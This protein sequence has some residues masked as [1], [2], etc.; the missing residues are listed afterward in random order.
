MRDA[1]MRVAW[2]PDRG[3]KSSFYVAKTEIFVRMNDQSRAKAYAD[4]AVAVVTQKIRELPNEAQFSMEL[5]SAQAVLG[6][7]Q[8]ALAAM[9]KAVTLQPF[10]KDRF[11]GTALYV[12]RARALMQLGESDEAITQLE[13]LL[14]V[15]SFLS[16]NLLRLD[17]IY[18][19]LRS[20]PR[21]QRLIQGS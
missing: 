1:A 20:N 8:E 16:R 5:A 4:S 17:P 11:L 21:F 15:P 6:R 12:S 10:A 13:Q 18:A 14:K 3:E 19:P 2:S 7:K 9:Q